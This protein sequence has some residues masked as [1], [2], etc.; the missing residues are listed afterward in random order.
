MSTLS[1]TLRNMSYQ[2]V[3]VD[4]HEV[5]LS[6]IA[7]I[8][9]AD[10]RCTL[11]A[12]VGTVDQ[13][14]D[15]IAAH[16]ETSVDLVMLDL[17]L[18]DGSDPYFNV[19]SFQES[20]IPVLIFSSLESPYLIRRALQAGAAG[21]MQKSAG[22]EEIMK[23]IITICGGDTFATADW[24]AI[25]DSDPRLRA[26]D[27]SPRQREV[28]ELY[29]SGESAKRVASLAGLSTDTVQDYINRI[30]HKY[31]MVGRPVHTKVDMYRRAQEDGYLP[32]PVDV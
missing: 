20:G 9:R 6:G 21:V 28:L 17:R 19:M 30:R 5:T 18:A 14:S 1:S 10:G 7:A 29:A 16:P 27:L 26:V 25:I 32:G 13:A 2:I 23:S 22:T 3:A 4:D 8:V 31:A 12:A 15:F 11:A 24:A